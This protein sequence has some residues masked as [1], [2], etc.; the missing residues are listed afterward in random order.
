MHKIVIDTNI[1]V[2]A[3]RSKQGASYKLLSELTK[4]WFKPAVSVPLFLEYEAVLKRPGLIPN[5]T[6][7]DIDNILNYMLSRATLL[8][9]FYL[10][11]PCLKDP[12][13]DMVLEL[14]VQSQ[15]RFIVTFNIKDFRKSELFGITAITPQQFLA[16]NRSEI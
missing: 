5:L 11:R 13:D 12:Q 4:G 9:I 7:V 1:L 10:W 14:A 3:L 6:A 15:S 2:A 8:Q 16:L